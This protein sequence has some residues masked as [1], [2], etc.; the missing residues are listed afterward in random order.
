MNNGSE[1]SGYAEADERISPVNQRQS[2]LALQARRVTGSHAKAHNPQK[3][4]SI[5]AV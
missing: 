1:D 5:S 4:S 2:A 3:L